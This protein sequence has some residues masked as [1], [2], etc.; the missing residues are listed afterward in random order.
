M[1][2]LRNPRLHTCRT[3]YALNVHG[4]A[5]Q[6]VN[7]ATMA[8]DLEHG[9]LPEGPTLSGLQQVPQARTQHA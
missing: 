1:R 8:Q 9:L 2:L 5:G 4:Q 6:P 3:F 7:A